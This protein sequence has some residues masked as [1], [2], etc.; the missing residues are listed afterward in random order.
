M[1]KS[2]ISSLAELKEEKRRLRLMTEVTKREMSHSLGFM[3]S[4]TKKIALNNIAIPAGI[5]A[6]AGM[7][8]KKVVS[9]ENNSE[10]VMKAKTGGLANTVVA[11]IPFAMKF[12][13]SQKQTKVE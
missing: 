6:A 12:L 9:S 11:L 8:L 7:L 4:E 13:E 3:R 10:N 1:K 5:T 2:K